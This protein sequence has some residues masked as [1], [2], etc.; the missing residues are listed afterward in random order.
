MSSHL[1]ADDFLASIL[2]SDTLSSKAKRKKQAGQP[3]S[4]TLQISRLGDADVDYETERPI[5]EKAKA[6]NVDDLLPLGV[7]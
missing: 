1:S 3:K 2:G 4:P 5:G 7:S 6:K